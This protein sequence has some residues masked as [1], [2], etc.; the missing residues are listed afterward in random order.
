MKLANIILD[1]VYFQMT[2][3]SYQLALGQQLHRSPGYLS[4]FRWLRARG[5]FIMVDNG[6]AEPEEERMSFK[7]VL[8][9]ADKIDADEIVL[10]DVIRDSDQTVWHT[11]KEAPAVPPRNRMIVPQGENLNEWMQC[12]RAIDE[13]LG[14]AFA[15]IGV[16]KHTEAWSGGRPR[17]LAELV[18]GGYA[19]KY[20][21]HLLG[22]YAEPWDE[23]KVVVNEHGWVRGIDTGLAIAMAQHGARI[24]KLNGRYSLGLDT[25]FDC[26]LAYANIDTLREWCQH[27]S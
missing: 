15:T 22:I 9:V 25:E 10:P 17:I 19:W 6:A 18:R 3:T 16:P 1:D 27:G 7:E 11:A 21:V 14:G 23:I 2:L 8:W 20:N 12:L 5:D 24:E 26:S 4:R 13:Q